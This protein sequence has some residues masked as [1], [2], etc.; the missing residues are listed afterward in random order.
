MRVSARGY[1]AW[2][3]RPACQRQRTDLKVLTHIREHF[4]LSNGSYGR[5]RMTM[6][7]REAGLDVGERRVGR[8]MKANGIRPV[9]TR[10]HKM[11][12]DSHHQSD[13]A[14]NLLDGNFL[15][16]GPNRKWAGDISYIWTAEGWLYLAVVIDL[17][18]RR[19]I[20]W[21]ASD[22]MKKDLAI[23]AL[24]MAVRLRNPAPGCI[25]HSDRGSQYGF[26]DFQKKLLA[27]G[28]LAS[29]SGKGNCFDNAAVETFFKSLKAEW[30]WRQNWPTR[31]QATTAIFQYINGFYNPRRRHSYLGGISPLAFEARVA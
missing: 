31:R 24:D 8:L 27:H 12:T 22:R 29:M 5:P 4:A 7:L 11:T 17:F 18:S 15:A 13:I 9:R 1:R 14:A 6:E 16:E 28:L 3:S 2:T 26:H 10:G 30:L 19:V 21:A 20:G 25:F 23:R